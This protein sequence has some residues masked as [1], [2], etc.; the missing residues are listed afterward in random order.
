MVTLRDVVADTEEHKI[1]LKMWNIF[2]KGNKK[3]KEVLSIL[4][5][6]ADLGNER[7]LKLFEMY[8]FG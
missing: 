2:L 8:G 4:F 5:G 3:T 6:A 7:D 1:M